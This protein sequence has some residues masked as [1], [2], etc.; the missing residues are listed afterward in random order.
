MGTTIKFSQSPED[1][2][3][4]HYLESIVGRA[5]IPD[6][7]GLHDIAGEEFVVIFATP[8]ILAVYEV[9]RNGAVVPVDRWPEELD[10]IYCP[11][12]RAWNEPASDTPRVRT[13]FEF[14]EGMFE[15]RRGGSPPLN[16]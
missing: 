14:G 5:I 13:S 3:L 12:P 10:E 6:R 15:W 9:A 11:K 2:A 8:S 16:T 7:M 1:R 4:G